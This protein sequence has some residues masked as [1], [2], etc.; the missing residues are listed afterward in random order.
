M[1]NNKWKRKQ[2]VYM[3]T[4]LSH[5]CRFLQLL[6]LCV[7]VCA[8]ACN[9]EHCKGYGSLALAV[10]GCH[11]VF[12]IPIRCPT[13]HF[14]LHH[15]VFVSWSTFLFPSLSLTFLVSPD[16][17]VLF[18]QFKTL[19]YPVSI[20]RLELKSEHI[21]HYFEVIQK[22]IKMFAHSILFQF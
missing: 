13:V 1:C 15:F 8:Y 11:R 3:D 4:G 19:G 9:D 2:T 6:C 12:S 22:L 18:S 14:H 5:I 10:C 21:H 7:C 20:F 16:R 17:E